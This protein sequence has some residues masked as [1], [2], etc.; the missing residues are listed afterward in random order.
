[1]PVFLYQ[2]GDD[3]MVSVEDLAFYRQNLP[4][5]NRTHTQKR[6]ASAQ[7]RFVMGSAGYKIAMRYEW[8]C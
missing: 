1:M 2:S 8:G 5:A 6:G 3:D 4:Q 7:Q